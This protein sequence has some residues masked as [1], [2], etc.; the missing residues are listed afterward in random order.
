MAAPYNNVH[1]AGRGSVVRQLRLPGC[2][3]RQGFTHRSSVSFGQKRSPKSLRSRRFVI[4][5]QFDRIE[6]NLS[7]YGRGMDYKSVPAIPK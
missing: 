4:G 1:I 6:M 2:A 7:V 5:V 3:V